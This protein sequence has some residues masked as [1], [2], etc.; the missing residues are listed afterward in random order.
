VT[1]HITIKGTNKNTALYVNDKLV[2][3]LKY[4][5]GYKADKKTYRIVRTLVFPL[6]QTGDFKSKI[7]QFKARKL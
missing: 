5:I 2:H 6:Q 3:D 1:E 4:G 7:T